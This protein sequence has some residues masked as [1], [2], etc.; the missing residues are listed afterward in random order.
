[1]GGGMMYNPIGIHDDLNLINS[2]YITFKEKQELAIRTDADCVGLDGE[3]IGL[4]E[5]FNHLEGQPGMDNAE[6]DQYFYHS[7][8]LGSS[9]FI[10]DAGGNA[11]QHLQY[12]PYGELFV[13]Q[14]ND[15]AYNTP[16]K[17]SAKEKDE[18]TGYSYFGARYLNPEFSI[19]LSVDPLTDKYPALSSYM[20]CA[21]NPVRFIDPDGREIDPFSSKGLGIF[22]KYINQTPMGRNIYSQMENSPVLISIEVTDDIIIS[23]GSFVLEGV[24]IPTNNNKKILSGIVKVSKGT[25]KLEQELFKMYNVNSLDELNIEQKTKGLQKLLSS[26]KYKLIDEYGTSID[27]SDIN[28]VG[29]N[30]NEDHLKVKPLQNESLQEYMQ[31]VTGHEGTHP[32]TYPANKKNSANY[33]FKQEK[34]AYRREGIII[35]QQ[36]NDRVISTRNPDTVLGY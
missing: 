24:F 2:D 6:R 10:T 12:L 34:E 4:P 27:L 17:F 18:E 15:A 1:M 33:E 25:Y 28:I 23:N 7:D 36:K 30:P 11:T 32:I 3:M 29:S 20:Y 35:N 31:R 16:Y 21:G 26:T 9:S 19:W 22:R 13:D 5:A 14:R 8:H